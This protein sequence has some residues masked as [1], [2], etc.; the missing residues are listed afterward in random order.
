MIQAQHSAVWNFEQSCVWRALVWH[1]GVIVMVLDLQSRGHGVNSWPFNVQVVHTQCSSVI[2][3]YNLVPA[4]GRWCSMVGKV[5]VGLALHWQ[6]V[7]DSVVYTIYT[8]GFSD[9]GKGWAPLEYSTF[10]FTWWLTWKWACI[11]PLLSHVCYLSDTDAQESHPARA[12]GNGYNHYRI[13]FCVK[14]FTVLFWALLYKMD[15]L[16]FEVR[17]A[18]RCVII[19]PALHGNGILILEK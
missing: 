17:E 15:S 14:Y 18:E 4:E 6:C 8:C 10:T 13:K 9:L 1:V 19:L 7:T 16:K 11:S 5:T 12:V 2:K 3:Q